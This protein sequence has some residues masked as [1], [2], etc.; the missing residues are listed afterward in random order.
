MSAS[1]SAPTGMIV[2]VDGGGSKTD[3]V[4]VS[5][6]G[7][8]LAHRRGP[9]TNPQ[10]QGIERA[11]EVVDSLVTEL[12]G[13]A[14]LPL[15]AS[16]V[17]L[18]GLDLEIEIETFREAV[19][20]RP[21]ASAGASLV[22]NDMFALLRTGTVAPD[23]VAV[24]CGTGINCVGVRH[25]GDTARFAALGAISGDWGGG[26]QLGEQALWHA[27]RAVDGRGRPTAFTELVPAHFSLP[28]VAAVTEAL[29]FGRLGFSAL[30]TLSPVVFAAAESGD[31]VATE[32]ID[33]Q[34]EEIVA[35]AGAAIDRLHL[36]DTALPVV[37]GGGVLAAA[38]PRFLASIEEKLGR[39]SP[40]AGI[41]LVRDRP[42]VGA[43]LLTLEAAG[44]DPTVTESAR[45]ALSAAFATLDGQLAE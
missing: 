14:A 40:R 32:L 39:R 4:A 21:W 33:R 1:G 34:A 10:T 27:A 35:L 36:S 5:L 42:I 11:V 41:T 12:V 16:G 43:A 19:A 37:L 45:S 2:A 6:D 23:A 31:S 38:S 3:A 18:S 29:H 8:L 44:A 30:A 9:A 13:S 7:R 24:V 20:H 15:L 25:D 26:Y 28:H 17:F 22:D